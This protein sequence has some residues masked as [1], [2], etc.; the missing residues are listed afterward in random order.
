MP[1]NFHSESVKLWLHVICDLGGARQH[2]ITTDS[3]R[4]SKA[5]C[6]RHRFEALGE[7]GQALFSPGRTTHLMRIFRH[8]TALSCIEGNGVVGKRVVDQK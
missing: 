8:C 2:A 5:S 6:T 1:R 4:I 3:A 7:H